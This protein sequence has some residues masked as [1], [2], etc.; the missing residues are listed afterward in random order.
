MS[1]Y[2]LWLIDDAVVHYTVHGAN[3]RIGEIRWQ[4]MHASALHLGESRYWRVHDEAAAVAAAGGSLLAGFVKKLRL[5]RSYTLRD[6]HTD[7][8]KAQRH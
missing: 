5:N 3:E 2:S 4:A 1:Q 7:L 6:D 8:A